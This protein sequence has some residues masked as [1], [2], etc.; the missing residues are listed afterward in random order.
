MNNSKPYR[1]C[2]AS[3]RRLR[4]A[5]RS[6]SLSL[7][8]ALSLGERVK[9]ALTGAQSG[10]VRV[11]LREARSSLSLRERV[12][13]SGNDANCHPAYWTNPEPSNFGK[14]ATV[15]TVAW[16]YAL[17]SIILILFACGVLAAAAAEDPRLK[18]LSSLVQDDSPRVRLEALRALAKIPSAKSAELAL[19]VLDKPM[20]PFLDY[21][22]WLTINDLADLWIAAIKSGEWKVEGH[23]KQLEFGLKA[24]DPA[25]ASQVLGQLLQNKPLSRDG[26]GGWIELIGRA[27]GAKELQRLFDQVLANGFDE[28]ASARALAA[29][30]EASRLRNVRPSSGLENAGK[31]FDGSSET[32]RAEA[33]KL[34]GTWK[35]QYFPRLLSV[36]G[37]PDTTPRLRQIAFD[38][39]REIGGPDAIAGLLPLCSAEAPLEIRQKA[40]LALAVLDLRKATPLAVAILAATPDENKAIDLWRGLL[41]VKGA[42]GSLARALPTSGFPASSAKAGLRVAR[43]GGRNEPELVLALTRSAGLEEAELTLTAAEIQQ[44]AASVMAQGDSARGERVFR[45]PE[46]GCV[47]CHAIGGVGGKVGPD[48]TSIG[49]SAP[50][51]YL[52]ESIFYPNRK[53][54]EGYHAVVLETQDGQELSGVLVRENNE[55]L[56]I[57]DVSNREVALSKNSIK[58]RTM[59]GSLMPSG[60]IDNVASQDRIDLFRFL[61]ELGKPGPY[62]ASKGGVARFWKVLPALHTSEQFGLDKIVGGDMAGGDWQTVYT[63]VDGR[64][65]REDIQSVM[66]Q[67]KY[68]GL[69]GIF[70]G[71]RFQL[72]STGTAHFKL[73][74]VP[75]ASVWID[76]KSVDAKPELGAQLAGGAHTLILRVEPTKLPDHVR[77]ESGDATFLTN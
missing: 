55:Q 75:G 8:P 17:R 64:L 25:K 1:G 47:T 54:K 69:V 28:P 4:A 63:L 44:I 38:S 35:D 50:V 10:L 6:G 53:I 13:V 67:N 46:L 36:A 31:L 71:A 30:N 48:L 5:W 12:R 3:R 58:N 33:L 57:R 2:R 60:L 23:E 34:A 7:T 26:A 72:A 21:A 45:R 27:G 39:L 59:G 73:S 16:N 11:S 42:A 22:L 40:V 49:A 19:S 32:I 61:S 70:L 56:V 74:L 43:E 66:R 9:P 18:P 68:A 77:L 15:C 76:G 51:D 65:L 41:N 14:S 20:D 62:D 29:L 24:I 37:A 52:V